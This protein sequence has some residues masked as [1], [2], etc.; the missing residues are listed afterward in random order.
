MALR[1]MTLIYVSPIFLHV[2]R[3]VEM[4][5]QKKIGKNLQLKKGETF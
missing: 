4:Q 2:E 5:Q 1:Y 3:S